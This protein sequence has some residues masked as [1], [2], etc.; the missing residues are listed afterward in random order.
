M[1][2]PLL[3]AV[4]P[5]PARRAEWVRLFQESGL[6]QAE[7]AP[8]EDLPSLVSRL[9]AAALLLEAGPGAERAGAL[10]AALRQ[11]QPGLVLLAVGGAAERLAALEGGAD[12]ALP[13]DTPP[14][15]LRATLL[16]LR[17]A[18]LGTLPQLL[19][20]E[21]AER[22]RAEAVAD[23]LYRRI[24]LPLHGLDP[25][26]RLLTVSDRWL[27]IFGYE[28]RREVIGRPITEFLAADGIEQFRALWP[29][30]RQG[31]DI[32][33]EVGMLHRS[34]RVMDLLVIARPELDQ[35]GRFMR[36]IAALVDISARKRAEDGLRAAQKME[37][38]GQLAGGIAHDMNNVLQTVVSGTRV[39]GLQA[40]DPEMVRR[41]AG[42][43]AEA[44]ERGMAIGRR[45]LSFARPGEL[46][47]SRADIAAVIED[48]REMLSYTLG[49]RI[50]VRVDATPEPG[51]VSVFVDRQQLETVLLNLVVNARDAMPQGGEVTLSARR[52]TAPEGGEAVALRVAD[53]GSGMEPAVLAR[54]REPFFTTKPRGKGTGLGLA[55]AQ[56]F[57]DQSGGSLAI[58]SAPGQGTRVTLTL[59]LGPAE[60]ATPAPA[61][62]PAAAAGREL[63]PARLLV[64]DDDPLVRSVLDTVFRG[65]GHQVELLED[66]AAAL[67]RLQEG[68]AFDLLLT[69]LAMPGLSGLDLLREARRRHPG[70]PCILLTGNLDEASA[71]ALAPI[72]AGG[73]FAV[74]R[75]PAVPE[76]LASAIGS[77]LAAEAAPG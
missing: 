21:I 47:A 75:K 62:A 76:A 61:P 23:G 44:G 77:L 73:P 12:A 65:L 56:S 50:Q 9:E 15:E 42:L 13:P 49:S 5:D 43:M 1:P 17:R 41:L 46:R 2:A 70:L 40:E 8:E 27:E 16:A 6:R 28:T 26:G 48:L 36:S 34:G 31:E 67:R 7:A 30:V 54:A 3:L 68:P 14:A 66:G 11:S 51:E 64:V 59:P 19:A 20:A 60:R 58:D 53:H 71:A 29:K 22:R 57:A 35:A 37:V 52:V 55:L 32:Q 74:L 45:L 18:R 24:P 25:A 63:P 69:D 39:L 10:C 4:S 38:F 33:C 72:S